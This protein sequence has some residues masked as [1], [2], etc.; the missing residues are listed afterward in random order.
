MFILLNDDLML[1][2]DSIVSVDLDMACE[3]ANV[4]RT[5]MLKIT[6]TA[7]TPDD[8]GTVGKTYS[9]YDN[10]AISIWKS[11]VHYLS[12]ARIAPDV[13]PPVPPMADD[14]LPF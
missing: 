14:D 2:T 5:T 8:Y 11:L 6:T 7:I 13:A 9:F 3:Y 4:R 1:N 10:V 12:P